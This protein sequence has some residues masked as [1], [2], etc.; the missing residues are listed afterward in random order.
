[1]SQDYKAEIE[2]FKQYMQNKYTSHS[3]SAGMWLQN[4][5]PSAHSNLCWYV[6]THAVLL[7][8]SVSCRLLDGSDALLYCITS[9]AKGDK[10]NSDLTQYK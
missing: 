5:T 10:K 4:Q 9:S 1:M 2:S 6:L 3:E 8:A 7:C